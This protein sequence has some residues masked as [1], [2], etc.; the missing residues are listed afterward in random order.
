M[1]Q[2][3]HAP[4]SASRTPTLQCLLALLR[5]IIHVSLLARPGLEDVTYYR[6]KSRQAIR[7]LCYG[8]PLQWDN[9]HAGAVEQRLVR[10]LL[11]SAQTACTGRRPS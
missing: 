9:I 2:L 3:A 8:E 5:T 11:S 4:S 1:C 6:T 7:V 10:R